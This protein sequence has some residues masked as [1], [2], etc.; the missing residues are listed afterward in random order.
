MK[1]DFPIGCQVEILDTNNH[2]DIRTG[3]IG[4]VVSYYQGGVGVEINR[5]FT[6]AA[7]PHRYFKQKRVLHFKKNQVAL[8]TVTSPP[9]P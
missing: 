3:D 4:T 2:A 5:E 1:K 7:D 6:T 8:Y 9:S